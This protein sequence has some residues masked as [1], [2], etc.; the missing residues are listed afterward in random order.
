MVNWGPFEF[1]ELKFKYLEG[2]HEMK[3]L[4]VEFN[5]MIDEKNRNVKIVGTSLGA[6]TPLCC[7]V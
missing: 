1:H 7:M 2:E 3:R 5:V 6:Y 4:L